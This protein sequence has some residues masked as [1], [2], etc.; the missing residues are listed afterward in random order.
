[1]TNE[2]ARRIKK[3]LNRLRKIKSGVEEI[4]PAMSR[5]LPDFETDYKKE[6]ATYE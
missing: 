1:M 5:G 4:I 2:E 6:R 3:E